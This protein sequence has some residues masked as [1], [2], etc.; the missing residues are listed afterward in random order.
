M[1]SAFLSLLFLASTGML[2][3]QDNLDNIHLLSSANHTLS[4]DTVSSRSPYVPVTGAGTITFATAFRWN[5]LGPTGG[6]WSENN[7]DDYTFRPVY[8]NVASYKLEIFNRNGYKVCESAELSRGWDGYLK[9]GSLA[10][11][12]VYI[13]KA[14]GKY[15]D[16]TPFSITGDVTFIH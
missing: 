15:S 8:S 3:S 5:R 11:Q 7:V 13:W 4:A 12:G 9:N 10:A 14:S 16:G 2:L 6:Y 1:K